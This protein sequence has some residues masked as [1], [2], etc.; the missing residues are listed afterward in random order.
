MNFGVGGDG[1]PQVLWRIREGLLDGYQPKAIVLCIG[2][3]NIWAGFD[4][5]DTFKGIETVVTAICGKCPVIKVPLI[6]NTHLTADLVH[7]DRV[8][9][10]NAGQAKL[11][12]GEHVEFIDFSEKIL[13]PD[14]SLLENL[15]AGD[16]LHLSP[17]GYEL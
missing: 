2:V 5:A 14:G 12:D 7:R 13:K 4:A 16:K 10:I 11:A 6:G 15:Y 8:R 9:A 1:T 17:A 3:N